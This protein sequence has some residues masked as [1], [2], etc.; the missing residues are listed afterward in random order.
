MYASRVKFYTRFVCCGCWGMTHV[1]I[2]I[3]GNSRLLGHSRKQPLLKKRPSYYILGILAEILR[4][5]LRIVI[6]IQGEAVK[7]H[8]FEQS[9][10]IYLHKKNDYFT[11]RKQQ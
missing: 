3:V 9:P 5:I 6:Q 7:R 2:V 11:K 8:D 10:I 4:T 1:F